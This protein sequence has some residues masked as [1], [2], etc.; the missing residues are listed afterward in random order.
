MPVIS[1]SCSSN[2]AAHPA[3]AQVSPGEREGTK[4]ERGAPKAAQSD[5]KLM[6]P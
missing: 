1:S 6:Q 5:L 4:K 2:L 3:S